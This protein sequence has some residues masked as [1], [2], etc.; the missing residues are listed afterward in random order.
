MIFILLYNNFLKV[1]Q[2]EKGGRAVGVQLER[3]DERSG[4][5]HE[6]GPDQE[7]EVEQFGKRLAD[8]IMFLR[9]LWE[10][11]C[12]TQV[13]R[14]SRGKRTPSYLSPPISHSSLPLPAPAPHLVLELL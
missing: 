7:G 4:M 10:I 2:L 8:K 9:S 11:G 6:A 14:W 13:E 12:N 1:T 3:D 5:G